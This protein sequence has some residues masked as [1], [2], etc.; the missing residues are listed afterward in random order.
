MTLPP[1]ASKPCAGRSG[2]RTKPVLTA[3]SATSSTALIR[4]SLVRASMISNAPIRLP[5]AASAASGVTSGPLRSRPIRTPISHLVRGG[6]RALV[7]AGAAVGDLAL[8]KQR[9]DGGLDGLEAA[10]RR[11]RGRA[12]LDPE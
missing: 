5:K 10:L 12:D 4:Q 1:A 7:R 9:A 8:E 6:D 2:P 11:R 3:L